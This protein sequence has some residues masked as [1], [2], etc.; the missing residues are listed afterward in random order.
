MRIYTFT[1]AYSRDVP[2][3]LLVKRSILA[4]QWMTSESGYYFDKLYAY[5]L[6]SPNVFMVWSAMYLCNYMLLLD[7]E[8]HTYKYVI[9]KKQHVSIDKCS[10]MYSASNF[11]TL[12]SAST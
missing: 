10:K 2:L 1:R 9:H 7:G 6:V 8:P 3:H 5:R 11:K 12:F 4:L